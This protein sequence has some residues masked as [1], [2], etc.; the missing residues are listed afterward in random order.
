MKRCPG[1]DRHV[2]PDEESCPFCEQQLECVGNCEE[3]GAI[4]W[5]SLGR[6]L[7]KYAGVT[8]VVAAGCMTAQPAYG[9][10]APNCPDG[11]SDTAPSYCRDNQGGNGDTGTQPEDTEPTEDAEETSDTSSDPS[12]GEEDGSGADTG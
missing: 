2:E 9:A 3:T 7:K 5:S 8:A 11:S 6:A 12:D 1:C 4:Q 10:P